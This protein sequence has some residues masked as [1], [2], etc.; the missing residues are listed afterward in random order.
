V[1]WRD[2]LSRLLHMHHVLRLIVNRYF[3]IETYLNLLNHVGQLLCVHV[4]YSKRDSIQRS[5]LRPQEPCRIVLERHKMLNGW[6]RG[7]SWRD[8]VRLPIVMSTPHCF[9]GRLVP[10]SIVRLREGSLLM[11]MLFHLLLWTRSIVRS[12]GLRG[13]TCSAMCL[14]VQ[15]REERRLVVTAKEPPKKKLWKI[16]EK[17]KFGKFTVNLHQR[18]DWRLQQLGYVLV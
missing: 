15:G 14:R 9:R 13:S 17:Q 7:G 8:L 1:R 16:A 11:R 4:P 18:V 2:Q 12:I 3:R 10:L 6:N 5:Y